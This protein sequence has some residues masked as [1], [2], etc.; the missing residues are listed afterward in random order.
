MGNTP[1]A[2]QIR[3]AEKIVSLVRMESWQTGHHLTEDALSDILVTSRTPVRGALIYLAEADFLERRPQK[4]FYVKNPEINPFEEKNDISAADENDIYQK[5]A[6]DRLKHTLPDTVS[7]SELVR[8]YNIS[9]ARMLHVLTR[10]ASEGWAERRSGNGWAF[11][12]LIDNVDAYK[13]NYLF[14]A[15]LE[16]AFMRSEDFYPDDLILLRLK[17]KQEFVKNEGY[18]FLSSIEFFQIDAEFHET[19]AT[20][21]GNRFFIRALKRANQLRR[22]MEYGL[23][24]DHKFIQRVCLEHIAV[25]NALLN[26]NIKAGATLLKNHITKGMIF[27]SHSLMSIAKE[28]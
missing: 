22:L 10:I 7:M 14:R 26:K 15:T 4:G 23:P 24:P 8:R 11:Q 3:L 20:M 18:K 5:I 16:P 21:T 25:I 6:L 28:K 27:K 12:T 19:L 13:E 2:L 17:E 9:R 1:S